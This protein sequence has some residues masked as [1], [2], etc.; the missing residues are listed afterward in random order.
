M[1][2]H[3]F[4]AAETL[5]VLRTVQLPSKI[6][7]P[8]YELAKGGS[9]LVV[10][11][12][13]VGSTTEAGYEIV[14]MSTAPV[15]Q[16]PGLGPQGQQSQVLQSIPFGDMLR[17]MGCARDGL[18]LAVSTNPTAPA[19]DCGVLYCGCKGPKGSY[20]GNGKRSCGLVLVPLDG[21]GSPR[22]APE[23]NAISAVAPDS[24]GRPGP[25][26]AHRDVRWVRL[27]QAGAHLVGF[28]RRPAR[29]TG[30]EGQSRGPPRVP[31]AEA[32]LAL[33][34]LQRLGGAGLFCAEPHVVPVAGGPLH[35][36]GASAVRGPRISA[37]TPVTRAA[38]LRSGAVDWLCRHRRTLG[39]DSFREDQQQ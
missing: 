3:F 25:E 29:C 9:E 28:A 10:L 34:E 23:P 35:G 11:C 36:T 13:R 24:V 14:R 39:P 30:T 8:R 19:S 21:K 16:A 4:V 1:C 32:D 17:Q 22:L 5:R 26:R 27:Q 2:E 6:E 38:H 31:Q 15:V 20:L 33:S 7:V 37:P 18:T 12:F